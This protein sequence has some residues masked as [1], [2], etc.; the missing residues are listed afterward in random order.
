M[1]LIPANYAE[2][3]HTLF[4]NTGAEESVQRKCA[5]KSALGSNFLFRWLVFCMTEKQSRIVV[6]AANTHLKQL[7]FSLFLCLTTPGLALNCNTGM[8]PDLCKITRTASMFPKVLKIRRIQLYSNAFRL[9]SSSTILRMKSNPSLYVS[10]VFQLTSHTKQ[11]SVSHLSVVSVNKLIPQ[12]DRTAVRPPAAGWSVSSGF[13]P[14]SE[15][16]ASILILRH[17]I[18]AVCQG[19]L[20]LFPCI[21]SLFPSLFSLFSSTNYKKSGHS[22]HPIISFCSYSSLNHLFPAHAVNLWFIFI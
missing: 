18:P 17:W 2:K 9:A 12:G 4:H 5:T 10:L 3:Q 20:T 6:E 21:S 1:S 19:L 22:C 8:Q 15:T 11:T 14:E 7:Q 13:Q 16:C